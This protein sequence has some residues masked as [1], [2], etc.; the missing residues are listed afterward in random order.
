[1]SLNQLVWANQSP[2][3]FITPQVYINRIIHL[4]ENSPKMLAI[5]FI[6]GLCM[7]LG[8][9]ADTDKMNVVSASGTN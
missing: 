2:E 8:A 7:A 9:L 6:L 4:I 5:K 1:M 3:S